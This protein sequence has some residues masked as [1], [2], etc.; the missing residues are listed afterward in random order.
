MQLIRW[1]HKWVGLVLGIQFLLWTVS[2]AMMA[3]LDHHKVSAEGVILPAAQVEIPALLLP[4]A[5]IPAAV[6]GTP[7]KL[8]LKPMGDRYVYEATTADGVHVIDA[9]DGRRIAIDAA[10]AR[11][12]A[13]SRFSGIAPVK[14][15]ERVEKTTLETRD[16]SLPIWRVE[17]TDPERTTLLVSA[18]NGDVLKAKNNTWRLFDFFWMLHI[19][20]YTE[21]QSFNHPLII[22]VATGVAWLAIT[23]LILL[24][25][26]F[27]ATDFTWVTGPL[28][29][30]S[31]RRR[32][33]LHRPQP[34]AGESI[35]SS[36]H[37][38]RTLP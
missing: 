26:S 12:L 16:L 18:D 35:S 17:F 33:P 36:A 5:A 8:Q 7:L 29:R 28:E 27:R 34:R 4:L 3:L 23:G 13:V 14:S 10:L 21:R 6:G 11:E 20:D 2:G 37:E 25:R 15:V 22:T 1:M 19:M 24:F 31:T 9:E 32:T 30:L 38:E